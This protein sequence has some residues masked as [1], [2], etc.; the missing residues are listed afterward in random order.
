MPA[1]LHVHT[2]GR[3]AAVPDN[4][5]TVVEAS[6]YKPRDIG[7]DYAVSAAASTGVAAGHQQQHLSNS[8]MYT[9]AK[10]P[11]TVPV[12]YMRF[13]D[14]RTRFF[15]QT[16]DGMHTE[17]AL[18]PARQFPA[19]EAPHHESAKYSRPVCALYL[20]PFCHALGE[21]LDEV[22]LRHAIGTRCR[23]ANNPYSKTL[24][25]VDTCMTNPVV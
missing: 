19:R 6:S 13:A 25:Q 16:T 20:Q 21:R 10:I 22:W 24:S 5:T 18:A 7:L 4:P 14:V 3:L 12:R 9:L 11:R 23:N 2:R 1:T 8:S 15:V 17:L